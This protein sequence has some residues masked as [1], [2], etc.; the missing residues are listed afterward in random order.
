[1]KRA[2][3]GILAH[4]DAG[5]TT[6]AE[7]LMFRGGKLKKAGRVDHGD[8]LLDSHILE[9]ERGITIF[10]SQAV[11]QAGDTEIT[12]LDT[13]GH[14]DFSAEAERVLQVL[15]YAIL[16]ISG[17]DGVQAHTNTLWRLLELY[18]IP[19]FIFITKMDIIRFTTDELMEQLQKKLS[20]GCISFFEK[21]DGFKESAAMTDESVL[22]KYLE[23][24][25]VSEEDI[26]KLI[27][28]RKIFPVF[29]GSGLKFEGIDSFIADIDRYTVPVRYPDKFGGKIFKISYDG[30]NNRL[31]HMKITGGSLKVRDP[32]VIDGKE[33]KVSQ[34]RIYN[35]AKFVPVEEVCT[36]EVCAVTGLQNTK[37]GQGLGYE[38]Q[39]KPP[40][41][42]PV[43]N[44]RIKLPEGTDAKTMMPKLK[45][46]EEEDPQLHITWN[47]HQQEIHVGLMGKVQTEILKSIIFERFGVEV[48]IDSG[49]VLYKETILSPVEGVGH[50]EPLRHYAEVHLLLEPQ[51]RGTGITI[52]TKCSENSLDRNWQQ[53]ILT[54]IAEKQH[55]GVL[56]GS[57]ITDMKITLMSGRSHIKHTVGGDFRQATYRAIR[58]GLMGAQSALLEPYYA[59]R[60]EV[61]PEQIGRAIND[62]RARC[63]TFEAPADYGEMALITG[64]APV[65]ALNDYAADVAAY[66][67][68]HGKLICH[69]DG[70]DICHNPEEVIADFAY[71]LE[72]D[73]ENTPDSVFCAHGA[74]FTV[75]WDGV[76]QYMHLESC[77]KK[78]AEEYVPKVYRQNLS[79]D[80]KELEAIMEREFG[81]I[82]R[83]QYRPPTVN[84]AEE[85]REPVSL[86]NTGKYLIVDGYNV[87]F[88][89]ED[90][91]K[92]AETEL[93]AARVQLMDILAG[94]SAFTK[95]KVV[96]VFDA[97]KVEG[98]PGKQFDYNKIN[99]VYTKENETGDLFIEKLVGKIGKNEKVTV[100]TSD[101]LIQLSALRSG[102]LRMS[103]REFEN[104]VNL[105]SSEI[106]KIMS[107]LHSQRLGTVGENNK[108]KDRKPQS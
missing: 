101:G 25:D 27:K 41:L 89:W 10:S 70:Y 104:E 99:V 61:P 64:R 77:I 108:E 15:D 31:T 42:E 58:Q 60:L 23:C 16:V 82:K 13:P 67:H 51:E 8:T 81:P 17:T 5:K 80:D 103:A 100:V 49:R 52:A 68:G 18:N 2:V 7:A 86:R 4:V 102:V 35:G 105:V 54:H 88:A 75:K 37:N 85:K 20:D 45:L 69:V 94:Y 48:E 14:V 28:E 11:M 79:I 84:S 33:E 63:G 87:I 107:R 40:V 53:L 44:Y 30:Q 90:L 83:P 72:G 106:H 78:E 74:G 39:S 6:L 92:T 71:D 95:T 65:S 32:V 21:D 1:M 98:N 97:Y 76:S 19:T 38:A 29:F 56:T 12:L 91:A 57:P 24:G 96:L 46:L 43:M 59:F 93:E 66:T 50:Y 36:G 34:I 9:K 62:I 22:E 73:L 3:I 26:S 47:S 55:L